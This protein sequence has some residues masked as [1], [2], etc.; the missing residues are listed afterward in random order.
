MDLPPGFRFHP[1]DE[2]L[3]N[4]YLK[5]KVLHSSDQPTFSITADVNIYKFDPWDLPGKA[6]FGENE[7]FFFSPRDRK[8]PNGMRPNRAAAS[9]FWKASGTDKPII[10]SGGSRCLGMK[11]A[12][13]FYKGR[14]TKGVKT[15]WVMTEYRLL[16]D[17]FPSYRPKGSMRL[18][19]WVLCRVSHKGR[20]AQQVRA[21]RSSDSCISSSCSPP[22]MPR[23]YL[24]GQEMVTQNTI[25]EGDDSLTPSSQTTIDD[26]VREVLNS[27]A[28]VLSV[29]ALDELSMASSNNNGSASVFQ[30]S[31]P[32]PSFSDVSWF[33]L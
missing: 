8:Y 21:G 13:A 27:I 9:G 11:K 29:G 24:Q 26:N 22:L 14:P 17:H 30:I 5:P 19:D 31:S 12:L 32:S 2:E 7:W 1:T 20:L 4:H 23:G 16:S 28:R 10:A 15:G 3:I 6:C 25:V 18:D 33:K